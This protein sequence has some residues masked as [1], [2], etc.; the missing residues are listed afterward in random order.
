M[1]FFSFA[2]IQWGPSRVCVTSLQAECRDAY[3]NPLSSRKPATKE[4]CKT[5]KQDQYLHNVFI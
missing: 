5:L 4:L 1:H 2:G 3:E